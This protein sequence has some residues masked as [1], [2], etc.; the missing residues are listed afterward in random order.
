MKIV[1][2]DEIEIYPK[3]IL[4]AGMPDVIDDDTVIKYLKSDILITDYPGDLSNIKHVSHQMIAFFYNLDSA[5]TGRLTEERYL[6]PII[7]DVIADLK[8]VD[9]A[10]VFVQSS[11]YHDDEVEAR[12]LENKIN[13]QYLENFMLNPGQCMSIIQDV[14][15]PMYASKSV[16]TSLRLRFLET[17]YKV[18]M[19]T[20]KG[21]IT[22]SLNDISLSGMGIYV[23]DESDM[24]K[25]FIGQMIRIIIDFKVIH[26]D[27]TQGLIMR[28][29]PE[30]TFLG[31]KVNPGDEVMI[32]TKNSQILG[33]IIDSHLE[34]IVR[35]RVLDW[36]DFMEE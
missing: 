30:L 13:Y 35:S 33:S 22:G 34:K 28:M 21:E 16:R 25:F 15:A 36:S 17:G 24:D 6:M 11:R 12:F 19:M 8:K 5:V 9:H 3:L 20:D 7:D 27:I 10:A 1:L 31:I 29:G 23:D 26:L 4:W 14:I 32:D 18:T 2:Q